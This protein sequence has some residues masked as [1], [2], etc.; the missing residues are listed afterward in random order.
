MELLISLE[1]IFLRGKC[2]DALD[3][4]RKYYLCTQQAATDKERRILEG[5]IFFL[6]VIIHSE[7]YYLFNISI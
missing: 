3:S 7:H 6:I 2:M 4:S 5:R 1:A